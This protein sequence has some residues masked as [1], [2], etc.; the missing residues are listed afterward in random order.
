[1]VDHFRKMPS[2][3]ECGA[4]TPP[5]QFCSQY[6]VG[7]ALHGM[8]LWSQGTKVGL[9]SLWVAMGG[10]QR[11]DSVGLGAMRSKYSQKQLFEPTTGAHFEMVYHFAAEKCLLS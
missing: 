2:A 10:D 9:G 4:N 11:Q 8:G 5:G 7:L 1:M 3:P 6:D